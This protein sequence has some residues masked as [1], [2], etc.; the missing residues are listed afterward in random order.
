MLL[1]GI[2][3]A[4]PPEVDDTGYEGLAERFAEAGWAA[5]WGEMRGVRESQGHFSIEGWVRDA[6]A[7]VDAVRTIE[8][9]AGLSLALV[10]SSAGGSVAVEATKRGAPVNALALLAAPAAWVSF[11]D[12]PPAAVKKITEEAG[13]T[14]AEEVLADPTAWI[15]EFETVVTENSVVDIRVPLLIVHGTADD[16]VPVSHASRIADRA[17]NPEVK[18][19]DGALHQ[20]RRDDKAVEIVLDW[21]ERTF[22]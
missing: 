19:I 17:R 10:G 8:G 18:I 1:H 4:A 3:S 13:M 22:R 2:P 12:D 21:L 7:I 11:A 5:A 15:G 16:V 6:R 14:L 9:L 20:L